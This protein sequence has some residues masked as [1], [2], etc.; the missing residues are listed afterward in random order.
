MPLALVYNLTDPKKLRALRF[1]LVKLGARGKAVAP[2]A[3]AHPVG[4]LCGLEGFSPAEEPPEG[5]F[6][7]EMLVLCGFSSPQLDWLLNKL[8]QDHVRIALKAVVTEENASWSSLRL[9]E[10]LR[11]EH[12][13]MQSPR[14]H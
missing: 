13:A 1:A 2:D 9:H 12:E 3:F 5:G 8:R 11:R 6:A 10:E 7:D 14:A 4:W